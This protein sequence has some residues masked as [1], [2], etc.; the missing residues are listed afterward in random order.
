MAANG[1]RGVKCSRT[2]VLLEALM[3]K[4]DA[5]DQAIASVKAQPASPGEV[6]CDQADRPSERGHLLG[7]HSPRLRGRV[8]RQRKGKVAGEGRV[9]AT[10]EQVV[11]CVDQLLIQSIIGASPVVST[12]RPTGEFMGQAAAQT[13]TQ[14]VVEVG[15]VGNV[16]DRD[17][18]V[19]N[20]GEA[21]Q[22]YLMG[23]LAWVLPWLSEIGMLPIALVEG[24][25]A[26]AVKDDV[27]KRA[28]RLVSQLGIGKGSHGSQE[29]GLGSCRS[30]DAICRP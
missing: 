21:S 12:A 30:E 20:H 10:P 14:S 29:K 3:L 7:R 17:A 11:D 18:G 9:E 22:L 4:M 27:R 5:I 6:P 2:E 25:L 15:P 24:P 13:T 26:G 16:S 23:H 8:R 1:Q 19:S 28:R